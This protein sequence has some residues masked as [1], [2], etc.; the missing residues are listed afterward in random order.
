VTGWT[1]FALL[2]AV[3]VV[4]VGF[5]I[6]R[7]WRMPPRQRPA[8]RGMFAA[9][10]RRTQRASLLNAVLIVAFLGAVLSTHGAAHLDGMAAGACTV[11]TAALGVVIV[12]TMILMGTVRWL[13]WPAAVVPPSLRDDPGYGAE[14]KMRWRDR[15]DR[16]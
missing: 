2:Y 1:L 16:R 10:T 13:N 7:N 15:R 11:L 6:R 14:L 12:A 4:L 3:Y 5:G 9:E 8:R